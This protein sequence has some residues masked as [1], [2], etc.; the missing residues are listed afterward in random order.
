M[1]VK[2]MARSA[3]ER[4]RSRRARK[5]LGKCVLPLTINLGDIADKL[6]DAGLLAEW[7][8]EDAVAIADA[9]AQALERLE[10]LSVTR[11][12]FHPGAV[13]PENDGAFR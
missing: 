1:T 12:T 5:A 13:L 6:V 10:V 4:Q 11:D 3:A 7:S 8:A 9:L 2:P